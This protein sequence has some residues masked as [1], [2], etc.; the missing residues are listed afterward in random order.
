MEITEVRSPEVNS[1]LALEAANDPYVRWHIEEH[2]GAKGTF[3][4]PGRGGARDVL[5]LSETP[6]GVDAW[7]EAQ[8]DGARPLLSKL[9]A[10]R[11]IGISV[12]TESGLELVQEEL[13]GTARPLNIFC[14]VDAQRF[15]PA[16]VRP[17]SKLG[18]SDRGALEH[19]PASQNREFFLRCFDEAETD[20]YGAYHNGT[21]VGYAAAYPH[22][23]LVWVHVVPDFRGRGYGR[24]LLSRCVTDLLQ[25]HKV[26]F[27]RACME[28]M[29]NLRVCLAAGFVPLREMFSF[30][31][32]RRCS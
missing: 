7:L 20:L 31:G 10:G 30:T 29:A 18:P 2:F 22:D 9:P 21:I 25:Q 8:S 3:Y 28:D 19:Y 4:V 26:A 5:R 14:M 11:R 23:T 12:G 27:W 6:H 13:T 32:E 1:Y 16:Q 15:R 17:V 24:S